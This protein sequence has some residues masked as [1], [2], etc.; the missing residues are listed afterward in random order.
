MATSTQQSNLYIFRSWNLS[1]R[2][3]YY[4]YE[5]IILAKNIEEA[6][7]T[8]GDKVFYELQHHENYDLYFH[9][10]SLNLFTTRCYEVPNVSFT[11]ESEVLYI[12]LI[13]ELNTIYE[14]IKP[15]TFTD[16]NNIKK[17]LLS[18]DSK[19]DNSDLSTMIQV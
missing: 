14:F 19:I 11:S 9:I 17:I 13:D 18:K 12:E 4:N 8:F 6:Y 15:N 5:C 16:E 1:E 10:P 7:Y 2:D 3:S